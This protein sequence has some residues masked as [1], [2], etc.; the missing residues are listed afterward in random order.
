MDIFPYLSSYIMVY[1]V[2]AFLV[3]IVVPAPYGKFSKDYLPLQ[4]NPRLA[5]FINEAGGLLFLLV[6]W[7]EDGTWKHDFPQTGK[8]WVCFMF[9]LVHF[10]W[11]STLSQLAIEYIIKPPNG[12]KKTS[13]LLS[14]FGLLYTAFVG[15]NLRRMCAQI[16]EEYA[17]EDSVFLVGASV[18]LLAN[19][20]MDMQF[21]IWRKTEGSDVSEYFGRYL[22]KEEIGERFGL[23]GK[24]GFEC[25]NYLFEMLEWGLFTLLAFKW[26][27]F[28]W[29]VSTILFLL[30]RSIWTSHW[31]SLGKSVAYE[32]VV[33][34]VFKHKD[35]ISF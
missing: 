17:E 24:L 30:P 35:N 13:I 27:A 9:L 2:V 6:G 11:R 26:E 12:T 4:V 29:F 15:M 34:K 3:L 33:P 28:W 21:N 8:G 1:A 31:Y 23:L 16:T 18:C 25:P 14:L 32:K 5:W 22:T 19:A 7:F 20:F 10:L